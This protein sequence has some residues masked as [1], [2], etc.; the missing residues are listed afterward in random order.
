MKN[1]LCIIAAAALLCGCAGTNFKFDQAR[2][3]E[4]GMT[5]ADVERIMGKPYMVT[6]R[7]AQD[8]WVY[9]YCSA[10]FATKTVSFVFAD[11]KVVEVPRIPDSF[12]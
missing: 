9:S 8:I 11:G 3:V 5:T 10:M 7:G 4:I 1:L 12:K 2:Q 6:T